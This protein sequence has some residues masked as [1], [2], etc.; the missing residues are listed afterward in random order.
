MMEDPRT[1]TLIPLDFE[2]ILEYVPELNRFKVQIDVHAFEEPIDSSDV[3]ISTWQELV[4]I[5]GRAYDQYDGFVILHGTDTMA[6]SASALSFMLENLSKPVVF[7]GSQVPI[8]RIRTDGKENLITAVE[9]AAAKREN[10]PIVQEVVICFQSSL[11]RG[12]RTHKHDTEEFD[13]FDSPNF[14]PLAQI[15]IH[16]LYDHSALLRPTGPLMI[17][18]E[19]E[20]NVGL[21]KIYPGIPQRL[22]ESVIRTPGLKGLILETYGSGNA[23][24]SLWFLQMIQQA[25]D[26]GIVVMNISQCSK[27][28]VEQGRYS[29]SVHLARLGVIGGADMTTEAALAKLM[30]LLGK[31]L[32]NEALHRQLAASLRGEQTTSSEWK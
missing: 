13:A 27:G 31:N 12:N 26:S 22:V 19:W 14:P 7:T 3:T 6:Y 23:P 20:S 21:L 32:P 11:F 28:F 24:T 4:R 8:G 5:I 30:F 1:G 9:V 16:I 10:G 18:R 17:H 25:I 2:H 15:G 29:T